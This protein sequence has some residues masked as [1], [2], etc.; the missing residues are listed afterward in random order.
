VPGPPAPKAV[1]DARALPST[2]ERANPA[3]SQDHLKG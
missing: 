1:K 3:W 2:R